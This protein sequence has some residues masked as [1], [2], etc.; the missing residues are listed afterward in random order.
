MITQTHLESFWSHSEP[1]EVPLLKQV[2]GKEILLEV[3]TVL[4]E[5]IK[6]V[7]GIRIWDVGQPTIL[8]SLI[9]PLCCFQVN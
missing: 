2:T 5:T 6:I 1:S 7:P 8:V 9:E 3:W 4:Y